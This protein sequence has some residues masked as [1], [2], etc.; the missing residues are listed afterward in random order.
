MFSILKAR[1]RVAALLAL[2]TLLPGVAFADLG[3]EQKLPAPLAVNPNSASGSAVAISDDGMI[4]AVGA[5]GNESVFIYTRSGALWTYQTSITPS[6]NVAGDRFGASVSLSGNAASANL[7]VGAPG[8]SS[9]AGGLYV[10]TGSGATWTAN[11]NN[12]LVSAL[13]S[14]GQLGTSVSIQGFRVAG[15]APFSLIGTKVSGV[16]IVF[17]SNDQGAT[18]TRST[19]RANGGQARN[20]GLFGASI[21]LSGSTVLVGAPGYHT[22]NKQNSGTVFVFV[23]NGGSWQ[24]QANIRPANV[25][26]NFAGAAVSLFNDTAAFGAPGNSNGKGAVYVYNRSGTAWSQTA[27]I[28]APGGAAGDNF[29]TSVAQLGPFLVA[30]S[31]FNGSNNGA[32]FEFGIVGG[33]YTLLNQLVPSDNPAGG[34]FG[35][36]VGVASGRAIVGDPLAGPGSAYIFKFLQPSVTTI[37]STSVD[38]DPAST[39]VPYTVNV[40]VAPDVGGSGTP[41]GSVHIDDG[42][43]GSCDTPASPAAGSLDGS[44]NGYCQVTSSHFGF[45]TLTATYGGDLDF[46]PSEGTRGLDV[47]GDHL[48]FNPKPPADVL[49]DNQFEGTVEIRNGADQLI[50]GSTAM[51]LLGVNDSCGNPNIIGEVQVQG[52]IATFSGIGPRFDTVASGLDISASAGAAAAPD[53]SNINVTA[54]NPDLI[55]A[56]NFD[57]CSL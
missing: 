23:R 50:T 47:T 43:G 20:G 29:G 56:A 4:A 11:T 27:A 21:S 51:V 36:S 6:D 25:A 18:F 28:T 49:Q 41:T 55:L 54:P 30:G 52:G 42:N 35:D 14:A 46:S 57:D 45:L 39:G 15:G 33:S 53:A 38:P 48:V 40:N 13:T 26:N 17:D 3:E 8:R 31:P 32:A 9:N 16:A 19:F 22:G 10:F 1:G 5:P 44:G 34:E 7:A 37:T 12:P 24:Q 2:L